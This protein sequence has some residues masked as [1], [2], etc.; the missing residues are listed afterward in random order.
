MRHRTHTPRGSAL[1]RMLGPA[2]CLL[3]MGL[4]M[5]GVMDWLFAASRPSYQATCMSNMKQLGTGLRMYVMDYDDKLPP[6]G[7]WQDGSYPYVKNLNVYVC[8]ARM[9]VKPGY[10]FNQRLE[11]VVAGK[12]AQP[13]KTPMLFESNRGQRN[14]ADR[15]TSFVTPHSD[16]VGNICFLDG[17][18]KAFAVPPTADVPLK[19]RA[20]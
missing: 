1:T 19:Q 16:R 12:A 7:K 13:E 9:D 5:Y 17:H 8:P 15:L 6:A 20:R 3:L 4:L 2:V 18:V 10:A 14:G 11:G